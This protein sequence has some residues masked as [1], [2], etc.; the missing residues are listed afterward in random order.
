MVYYKYDV[1]FKNDIF[2]LNT[3]QRADTSSL[4]NILSCTNG[5]SKLCIFEFIF[6]FRFVMDFML[7]YVYSCVECLGKTRM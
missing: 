6:V 1:I 5:S 7:F 3:V 2:N 4:H